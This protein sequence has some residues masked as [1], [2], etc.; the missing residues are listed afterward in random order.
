MTGRTVL[1]VSICGAFSVVS[2][3]SIPRPWSLGQCNLL[4]V[5]A[6]EVTHSGYATEASRV[7]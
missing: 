1:N 6:F 3:R 2:T 5:N 4:S 7:R